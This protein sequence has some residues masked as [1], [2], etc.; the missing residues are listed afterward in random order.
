MALE[1]DFARRRQL[2][3]D[4]RDLVERLEDGLTR[5]S[6]GAPQDGSE[7]P[8]FRAAS[9][10]G[11]LERVTQSPFDYSV[12]RIASELGVS[13]KTAVRWFRTVG[14][15]APSKWLTAQRVL[16]VWVELRRGYSGSAAI[17]R[18]LGLS[19]YRPVRTILQ[20]LGACSVS[21]AAGS[22]S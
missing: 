21:T 10:S 14:Q 8:A 18:E 2:V 16:V 7:A 13:T 9:F 15:G 19:D 11:V 6:N 12:K 20:L 3:R 4:L 5:K 22:P 17:S 1:M